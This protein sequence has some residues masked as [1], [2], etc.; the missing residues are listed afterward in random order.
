MQSGPEVVVGRPLDAVGVRLH[1]VR[2]CVQTFREQPE[3]A[4]SC[5][6]LVAGP[7]TADVE[8]LVP[9]D[10]HCECALRLQSAP[11]AA[12]AQHEPYQLQSDTE[13][14]LRPVVEAG[15]AGRKERVEPEVVQGWLDAEVNEGRDLW[16]A[17]GQAV[18]AGSRSERLD[19][20]KTGR[21]GL[22]VIADGV[23][24]TGVS[25]MFV[26]FGGVVLGDAIDVGKLHVSIF[27]YGPGTDLRK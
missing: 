19:R 24:G 3:R 27:P 18:D 12:A 16:L 14:N 26:T 20:L 15:K 22:A 10:V 21:L 17:D 8:V 4:C 9:P 6:R 7:T 13:R 1:V 23:L 5:Q 25:P 11:G 2:G